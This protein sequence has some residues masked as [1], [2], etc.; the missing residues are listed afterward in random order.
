MFYRLRMQKLGMSCCLDISAPKPHAALVTTA[1]KLL[2]FDDTSVVVVTEADLD[3]YDDTNKSGVVGNKDIWTEVRVVY[4]AQ[5]AGQAALSRLSCSWIRCLAPKKMPQSGEL[6]TR[7][8]SC[9]VE[10]DQ[11]GNFGVDI[12]VC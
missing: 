5:L 9:S 4:R 7:D 11:L 8:K 3:G 1:P 12:R 6:L 2:A 10:A